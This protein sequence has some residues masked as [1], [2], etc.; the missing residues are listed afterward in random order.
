MINRRSAKRE[1]NMKTTIP[2][3]R[4]AIRK[5]ITESSRAQQY[6]NKINR[7]KPYIASDPSLYYDLRQSG[8]PFSVA[9]YSL[10]PIRTQEQI[11]NMLD[12]EQYLQGMKVIGEISNTVPGIITYLLRDSATYDYAVLHVGYNTNSGIL[13]SN[14]GS[15]YS[16]LKR[17]VKYI[18]SQ[19]GGYMPSDTELDQYITQV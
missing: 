17:I 15:E 5:V 19:R 11:M 12:S 1:Y 6:D 16:M 13:A 8:H 2:K 10:E 4:K 14:F 18:R 7:A 9:H 3:L